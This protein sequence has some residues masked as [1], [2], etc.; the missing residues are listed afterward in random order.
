MEGHL[1]SQLT[2][3]EQQLSLASRGVQNELLCA[4]LVLQGLL[5]PFCIAQDNRLCSVRQNQASNG[6]LEYKEHLSVE[7]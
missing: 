3:P 2:V 1:L 6:L 7:Q 4:L 5:L